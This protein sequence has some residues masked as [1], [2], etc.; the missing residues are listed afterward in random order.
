MHKKYTNVL[1]LTI[2]GG[3]ARRGSDPTVASDE[4]PCY[5]LEWREYDFFSVKISSLLFL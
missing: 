1:Q 2:G 4:L 5:N 3:P